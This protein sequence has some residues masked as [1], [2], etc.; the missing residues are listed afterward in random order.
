MHICVSYE[1]IFSLSIYISDAHKSLYVYTLEKET[2]M[3]KIIIHIER[4]KK[5][6]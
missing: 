4:N 6:K 2:K 5:M 3:K 1:N